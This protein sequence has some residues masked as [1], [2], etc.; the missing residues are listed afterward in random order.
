MLAAMKARGGPVEDPFDSKRLATALRTGQP[1]ELRA[2]FN[3]HFDAMNRLARTLTSRSEADVGRLIE[4]VWTSAVA[5][6]AQQEPE[7]SVRA[8]LFSRL[9]EK[10]G[11]EDPD[12][13]PADDP[14]EG[15]WADFPVPWRAGPDD[16]EHSP[17]GRAALEHAIASLP[18]LERTVLIL[19]DLDGWHVPEVSGLTGLEPDEQREVLFNARLAIRAAID[20]MLREPA[21]AEPGG[22]G[23]D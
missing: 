20:P 21:A 14:W 11:P 12:F 5:D 8:W 6:F 1:D 10:C 13:L 23:H 22:D 2:A 17:D 7:G 15:H 19:R 4:A 9:L 16:W 18:R 3:R